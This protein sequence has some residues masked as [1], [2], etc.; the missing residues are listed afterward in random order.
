MVDDESLTH[1][2][3]NDPLISRSF[4]Y[5]YDYCYYVDD[6]RDDNDDDDYYQLYSC[7]PLRPCRPTQEYEDGTSASIR[8]R[9]SRCRQYSR[10]IAE[11]L[12]RAG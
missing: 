12:D 2:M 3:C 5:D 6:Y 7:T 9:T 4:D 10:R 11:D 1:V 8:G